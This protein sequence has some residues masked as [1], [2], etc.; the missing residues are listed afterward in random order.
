MGN[1]DDLSGS[2]N[3]PQTHHEDKQ[4][5]NSTEHQAGLVQRPQ[6]FPIRT[7]QVLDDTMATVFIPPQLR[8]LTNEARTVDVTA[9]NVRT[10]IEQLEIQF[11]GIS[12]R[13]CANG[14][15]RPDLNVTVDG[16]VSG[17][18][19]LHRLS[20]DSEVHFLPAIGGG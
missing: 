20:E 10:L 14:E 15:L 3:L 11:P 13:L 8:S 9:T 5:T 18:G 2:D 12:T 19:M 16:E 4:V 6:F 17:R 7:N 1:Q